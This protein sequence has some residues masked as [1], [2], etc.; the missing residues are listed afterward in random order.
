MK[1]QE[2]WLNHKKLNLCK[3]TKDFKKSIRYTIKA[4]R[5]HKG[6]VCTADNER[7]NN[8]LEKY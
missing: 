1:L 7:A 5:N 6:Y 8:R 3:K 2:M 4:F